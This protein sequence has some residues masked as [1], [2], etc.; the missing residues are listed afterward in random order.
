M[1]GS[2]A[3]EAATRGPA[4]EVWTVLR[5]M[6]WSGEY[7]EG[8]GV[9]RGRLDAEHLLA[10]ALGVGR[11]QLYL[12]FDR[13]LERRE[14]D[15]FRPL[16]RR[17]AQ[18]EPLQY[19]LGRAAFRELDL[20][21][22]RRVLIPR[23]ETEVLVEEVLAWARAQ[24]RKAMSAVDLGTGSGAIALSLA[25]EG[26]FTEVVAVDASAAALE[27]A[28]ENV[29]ASGLVDRVDLRR[30]S[31]FDALAAREAFDV[32]VSNPPYVSEAE[33]ATLQPEVGEWE[34]REALLGGPD[35]LGVIR[36]IVAGASRHMAAGGLLALEVGAGQAGLVTAEVESAG[37]YDEVRV[38]RDLSGRERVVLARRAMV[39]ENVTRLEGNA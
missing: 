20:H 32:V 7:L 34:P 1:T 4:D 3:A 17:R 29:R 24:R 38:R 9:E 15:R 27:V 39:A 8:K 37:G 12:Q 22:N 25:F 30:G 10:H 21:V 33:M 36:S 28:E 5:L 2:V 26:P 13:P 31:L 11:L 6:R 23:P 35:G 19:I 16:L 18:R 14:L